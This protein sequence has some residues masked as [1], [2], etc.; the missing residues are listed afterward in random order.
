MSL[1]QQVDTASMQGAYEKYFLLGH[2]IYIF[3]ESRYLVCQICYRINNT[4]N[5]IINENRKC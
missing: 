4:I 2:L 3:I 5:Y 1:C